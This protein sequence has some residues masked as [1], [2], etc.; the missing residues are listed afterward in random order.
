MWIVSLFYWLFFFGVLFFIGLLIWR[1][2]RSVRRQEDLSQEA[3]EI[4]ELRK[5]VTSAIKS[6]RHH[7]SVSSGKRKGTDDNEP[8]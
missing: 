5:E 7:L 8:N 4:R 1:W 6:L 2:I 3:R